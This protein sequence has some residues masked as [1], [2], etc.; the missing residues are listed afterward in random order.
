[1]RKNELEGISF[2]TEQKPQDAIKKMLGPVSFPSNWKPET[3]EARRE[4][5]E[6]AQIEKAKDEFWGFR[7]TGVYVTNN[8]DKCVT[9]VDPHAVARIVCD[10]LSVDSLRLV[11]FKLYRPMRSILWCAACVGFAVT[12]EFINATMSLAWNPRLDGRRMIDMNSILGFGSSSSI[13]LQEGKS[14]GKEC[15]EYA[16]EIASNIGL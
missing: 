7:V 13:E 10:L 2:I 4:E 6:L 9:G 1:M 5:M 3:I 16:L 15:A 12:E 8:P 14:P 11:G